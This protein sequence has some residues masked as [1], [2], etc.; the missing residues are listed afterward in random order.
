MPVW[1]YACPECGTVAVAS[2]HEVKFG[3]VPVARLDYL[4][5]PAAIPD[6]PVYAHH[7]RIMVPDW[8][9]L[10]AWSDIAVTTAPRPLPGR[11]SVRS[12]S[13]TSRTRSPPSETIQLYIEPPGVRISGKKGAGSVRHC[14]VLTCVYRRLP[15]FLG[16]RG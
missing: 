8:P 16:C 11:A 7:E 6:D 15:R 1:V 14:G 5:H 2:V 10:L 4:G 9:D 3:G 13:S 12:V